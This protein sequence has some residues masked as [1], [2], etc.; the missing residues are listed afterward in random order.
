[1]LDFEE[2][3]ISWRADAGGRS[4]IA[5]G[6]MLNRIECSSEV[7]E[8]KIFSY[9]FVLVLRTRSQV[10]NSVRFFKSE[11]KSTIVARLC[12]TSPSRLSPDPS[13]LP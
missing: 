10:M 11:P 3:R 8:S 9:I 5:E 1:M 6:A 2:S 4:A 13:N 12:P 7:I